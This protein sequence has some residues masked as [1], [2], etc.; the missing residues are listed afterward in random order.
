MSGGATAAVELANPELQLPAP[1][2]TFAGRDIFAPAAAHLCNG[3]ALDA[4]GP[5][6]DPPHLLPGLLPLPRDADDRLAAAVLWADRF[7]NCPL[8]S[9]PA[10]IV[11]PRDPVRT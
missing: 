9:E 6:I 7:G 5:A 11:H 2:A 1:G 4:L 10:E 8:N 3:V